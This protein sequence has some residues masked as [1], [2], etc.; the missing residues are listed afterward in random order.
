MKTVKEFE[1]AFLSRNMKKKEEKKE[2]MEIE[3]EITKK[4][5]INRVFVYVLQSKNF[6]KFHESTHSD[7][8]TE[9]RMNKI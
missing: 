5:T 4:T 6:R 8:E 9:K 1:I 7:E 3:G 2:E